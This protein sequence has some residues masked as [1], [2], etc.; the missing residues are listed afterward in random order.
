VLTK[1]AN[2]QQELDVILS[3]NVFNEVEDPNFVLTKLLIPALNDIP[4]L[5]ESGYPKDPLTLKE[6]QIRMG[7][8]CQLCLPPLRFEHDRLF[9]LVDILSLYR[10]IIT[11]SLNPATYMLIFTMLVVNLIRA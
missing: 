10:S 4:S 9:I 6:Y 8:I 3:G 2:F 1:Q 5:D 11:L 7:V